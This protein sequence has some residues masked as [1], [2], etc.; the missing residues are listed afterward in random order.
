MGRFRPC[1]AP[2][3]H[4]VGKMHQTTTP[5]LS[6]AGGLTGSLF[7]EAACPP[8]RQGIRPPSGVGLRVLQILYEEFP[9]PLQP[10]FISARARTPYPGTKKWLTRN[11]GLWVVQV[12]TGGWYRARATLQ[13]LRR[14]G[15]EP[16]KVH[17]LQLMVKSLG[18]GS[19]PQLQGLGTP[20]KTADGQVVRKTEWN[21]RMVT[22]Q[23]GP[24]GALVSVRASTNP[25]S[26]PL[27]NEL[28]AWL[29]GLATP[30]TVTVQD[31][32][33]NVDGANHRLKVSG[34]E[35][36]SLGGFQGGLLKIYNKQ[37]IDATRIEACFHRVNLGL[38]EVARVLNEL[39][40]PPYEPGLFPCLDPREVA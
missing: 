22:V 3:H 30:G 19:P 34:A 18:G 6:P 15:L 9:A 35:S 7:S 24:H 12:S 14:V 33:L 17:A 38:P 27:F 40:T 20:T 2:S 32:D 26:I 36:V 4:A 37:V 5:N 23:A 8:K 29:H 21:G 28:A 25:I 13:L 11:D 1:R 31:F 16:L 39:A 10:K